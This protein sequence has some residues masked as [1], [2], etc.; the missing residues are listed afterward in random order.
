MSGLK[1]LPPMLPSHP[2]PWPECWPKET[3]P[4]PPT[5]EDEVT[6][7]RLIDPEAWPRKRKRQAE[8][9]AKAKAIVQV[10]QYD[11]N[12][13]PAL[14]RPITSAYINRSHRAPKAPAEPGHP[15]YAGAD[16]APYEPAPLTPLEVALERALA[17]PKPPRP[18]DGEP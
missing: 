15:D 18:E 16:L 8:A 13:G 5:A 17:A 7:A 10:L 2:P 9:L 1:G 3:W 6:I 12:W 11:C 14:L 4:R